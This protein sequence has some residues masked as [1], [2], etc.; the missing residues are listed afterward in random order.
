M[1]ILDWWLFI[2]NKFLG[3]TLYK[4]GFFDLIHQLNQN[5][6][7]FVRLMSPSV[8]LKYV[9]L[10][11]L[12]MS[13]KFIILIALLVFIRGGIPRY[14]YDFL[15]KIGWIKFLSLVLVVFLAS[16]LFTLSL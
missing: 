10:S 4:Y 15:T 6:E 12:S 5:F 3:L 13:L 2:Y 8:L 1:N 9:P 16:I 11:A 14:R 7:D